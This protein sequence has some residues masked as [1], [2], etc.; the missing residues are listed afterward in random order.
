MYLIIF[1]CPF[2]CVN[3]FHVFFSCRYLF[4]FGL[5]SFW[6]LGTNATLCNGVCYLF[7]IVCVAV[8]H[9]L[10]SCGVVDGE[11]CTVM[12]PHIENNKSLY[13]ADG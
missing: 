4:L 2:L 6:Y 11:H 1:S 8:C 5:K 10:S 3:I 7:M 13:F 12:L 9:Q